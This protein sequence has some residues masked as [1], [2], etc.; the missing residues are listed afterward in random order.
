MMY[1]R[2]FEYACVVSNATKVEVEVHV[3]AC[4]LWYIPRKEMK[5]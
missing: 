1:G 5:I 2:I 3:I 4:L